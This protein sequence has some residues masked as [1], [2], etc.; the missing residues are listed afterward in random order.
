[1]VDDF[2]SRNVIRLYFF[3]S[4][5]QLYSGIN[6]SP[7]T[8]ELPPNLLKWFNLRESVNK[9]LPAISN[10]DKE[11]LLFSNILKQAYVY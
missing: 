9:K 6:L 7:K 10:T 4:I 8:I 3:K 11:K 1:M 5:S 2:S